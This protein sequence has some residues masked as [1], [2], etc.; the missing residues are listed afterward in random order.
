MLRKHGPRF[1]PTCVGKTLFHRQSVLT[2]T[3]HPH[4]CGE[5]AVVKHN[6]E[7]H[8]GSPPRVWGRHPDH[9]GDVS[10]LR[11]TPTCVGKTVVHAFADYNRWVHPHVC[12]EDFI[13]VGRDV[14]R[15][16]SPPRVWGRHRLQNQPDQSP[17]FTPTCVGKTSIALI[18]R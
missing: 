8:K 7:S 13:N 2:T 18:E 15:S 6:N 1:T 10:P 3:V 11:F 16:G 12:G 17:R 5:D 9:R 4:V 14:D